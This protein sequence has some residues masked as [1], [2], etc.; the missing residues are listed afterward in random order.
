MSEVSTSK[1]AVLTTAQSM[2]ATSRTDHLRRCQRQRWPAA[3]PHPRRANGR[4][5]GSVAA[6]Q[7]VGTGVVMRDRQHEG[8]R[9]V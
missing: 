1:P 8:F 4:R 7:A 6:S 5:F 9:R 3:A 2:G